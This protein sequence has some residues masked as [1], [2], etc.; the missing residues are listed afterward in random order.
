MISLIA[1]RIIPSL[2]KC[3]WC[4]VCRRV[5]AWDEL[6]FDGVGFGLDHAPCKAGNTLCRVSATR[7][8]EAA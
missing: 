2:G 6:R 8:S 7:E 1:S 3:V 5:H 4:A